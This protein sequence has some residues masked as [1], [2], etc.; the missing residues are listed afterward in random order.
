[1]TMHSVWKAL[2]R[3]TAAAVL[4]FLGL[5]LFC[6]VYYH[7]PV[8]V[9]DPDG[10]TNYRWAPNAFYSRGTEGFAWGKMNNEGYVNP[11]DYRE[12]DPVD[13][14]IVGSSHMEALQLPMKDATVMRLSDRFRDAK[15]YNIGM[16]NHDLLSCCSNLEAAL[17][18]YQ[19]SRC[20]VIETINIIFSDYEFEEVMR[21]RTFHESVPA[22]G[23]LSGFARQNHFLRLLH[24]QLESYQKAAAGAGRDNEDG[25]SDSLLDAPKNDEE[26]LDRFTQWLHGIAER[27]GTRLIIAYHPKASINADGSL[28]VWSDASTIRQFADLCEKNGIWFLDMSGRFASE[29]AQNHKLPYGFVNSAIG[30]GHFN[31]DGHAM[32]ADEIARIIEKL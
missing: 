5:S 11:G 12:G 23:I 2:G 15:V 8:R 32:F 4:A 25:I 6:E 7:L 1:M 29:Y 31:T 22:Q 26:V 18:K 9:E 3:I 30:D 19:P 20:A 17:K 16:S 14:L 24:S 28:Q 13:I 21:G 10:A 27:A